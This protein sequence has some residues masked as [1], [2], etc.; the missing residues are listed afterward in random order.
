MTFRPGAAVIVCFSVLAT[1]RLA[2]ASGHGPMFGMTTPPNA[3][4]GWAIDF[5]TMGRIGQP[6]NAATSR[7]MLTFGITE[8]LQVSGS[9]PYVFGSATLPAARMTGMMPGGGDLEGIVAWRFQRQGTNVGARFE[10]TAYGGLIVPGP[11]KPAGVVGTFDRAAGL[12]TGAATGFASR[13]TYVWVGAGYTRFAQTSVADRRSSVVSYSAV[14]GYR[15]PAM[16]KEY[17]HWDW[18]VFAEM[19]GEKS[20]AAEHFG[21]PMAGTD[22]HQIFVGPSVLGIYKNYAIQAGVQLPAYRKA[23]ARVEE[24]K[25]R[26]AA[27]VSY[28]F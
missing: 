23:G 25:F 17:P 22:A 26:Y 8:D 5:G 9:V 15:P 27:N 16:R 24:E 2:S 28:F 20:S 10:S 1:G 12:Y 3:A 11:Q 19:T 18:R 6:D 4:G 14:W 13:G 21:A 7:T